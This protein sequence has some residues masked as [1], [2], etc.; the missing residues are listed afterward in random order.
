MK[1]H[2]SFGSAASWITCGGILLA[3]LASAALLQAQNFGI[4]WHKIGSSQGSASNGQF[5]VS[6]SAGQPD[7][8]STLSG[9]PYALIGGFWSAVTVVQTPG[10]PELAVTISG[11]GRLVISWPAPATGF[12]LQQ[13]SNLGAGNWGNVADPV[14]STPSGYQVEVAFTGGH[15]FYRLF[16]P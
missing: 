10:A 7:A 15:T 16:R 6:G 11:P 12:V 4:D 8:H 14:I 5:S 3:G 13:N 9:G 2:Q 1:R